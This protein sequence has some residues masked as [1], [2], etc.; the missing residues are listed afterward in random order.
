MAELKIQKKQRSPWPW[1]TGIIIFA[2]FIWFMLTYVYMPTNNDNEMLAE[3]KSFAGQHYK[4]PVDTVNE[5]RE[6]IYYARNTTPSTTARKYTEQ[7]LIKLQSALSYLADNVDS[8]NDII[9]SK[10][11]S[12][13]LTIVKI[14]T[15]SKYYLTELKPAFSAAVRAM[16]SIQQINYPGMSDNISNLKATENSIDVRK[17]LNSQLDKIKLFFIEAGKALEHMKLSYSYSL[18]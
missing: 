11:D 16:E 10:I 5:V 12:L 3:D 17:S 9:T 6:F 13:D 14:D 7:G 18:K 2:G 8:T 15:S 1:I 4:P